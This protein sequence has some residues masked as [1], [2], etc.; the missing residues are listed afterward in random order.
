MFCFV[1]IFISSFWLN[2]LTTKNQAT[3]VILFISGMYLFYIHNGILSWVEYHYLYNII[4]RDPAYLFWKLLIKFSGNRP[5]S[6]GFLEVLSLLYVDGSI[7]R[8]RFGKRT[9]P[10]V[11]FGPYLLLLHFLKFSYKISEIEV[12]SLLYELSTRGC[13]K[14]A[15]KK[16]KLPLKCS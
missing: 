15:F 6:V 7:L 13:S 8:V 1:L 2:L 3:K 11:L 12:L 14:F 4:F 10:I 5:F 16:W 9:L